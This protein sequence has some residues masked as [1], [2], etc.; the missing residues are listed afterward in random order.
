MRL[1]RMQKAILLEGA[2]QGKEEKEAKMIYQIVSG[3][4]AKVLRRCPLSRSMRRRQAQ[5]GV[6]TFVK[7]ELA[8]DNFGRYM[9]LKRLD[10]PLQNRSLLKGIT[11][12]RH[13]FLKKLIVQNVVGAERIVL[14]PDKYTQ[15][16][17]FALFSSIA[18]AKIKTTT[19]KPGTQPDEERLSG[20]YYYDNNNNSSTISFIMEK[21]NVKPMVEKV[22]RS[23]ASFEAEI[24]R[25]DHSIFGDLDITEEGLT[26]SSRQ[27]DSKLPAYRLGP[28]SEVTVQLG[29]EKRK[30]WFFQDITQIVMR[31]YNL[32]RQAVEIFLT[33]KKSVFVVL[34]SKDKVHTFFS[35][36]RKSAAGRPRVEF[37][38]EAAIEPGVK[39]CCE[40]WRHRRIST[41]EYLMKLNFY[42]ARSFQDLSQYPIF[43]W[44]LADHSSSELVL[45]RSESFRDLRRPA[46][47]LS[48]KKIREAEAKFDNSDDFPDGRF[49]FGTHY[50]PGRV[51]L[52]YLMRM[53]PYTLMVDR[54]DLGGD[55][56]ARQF[57][58]VETLWN[59]ICS[60]ADIN[61]ELVPEF[62]YN[63]ELFANQYYYD[64]IC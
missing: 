47:A 6:D 2:F 46:A 31:R 48:D 12:M 23:E 52:S 30:T 4:Y 14:V 45:S 19:K 13:F 34:F 62:F 5:S 15:Q 27:K 35:R 41:F 1:K 16:I 40:D 20:P 9:R 55:L 61:Y 24:V 11:Y 53:Q 26:F 59:S 49:Q 63:P 3:S 37:V 44:V 33:S 60:E 42:G 25:L 8:A 32:I 39:R 57:H 28:T 51:V 21:A 56:P 29:R 38:E 54:F 17:L 18:K 10:R 50:M 7:L 64:L 58:A 43:P 36:V 22:W